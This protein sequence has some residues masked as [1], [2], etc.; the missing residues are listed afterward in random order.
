MAYKMDFFDQSPAAS[1]QVKKNRKKLIKENNA[2]ILISKSRF[3]LWSVICPA[4]NAIK[5]TGTISANPRRPTYRGSLVKTYTCH[6]MIINC[7]DHPK[8]RINRMSRK[9]LNSRIRRDAYGS[10]V[11]IIKYY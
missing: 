4:N 5:I 9:I 7:I 6:S 1:G 11:G 3:S 10:F 2:V 8:T